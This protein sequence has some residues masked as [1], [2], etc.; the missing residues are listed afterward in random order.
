MDK[1]NAIILYLRISVEDI[2]NHEG[3]KDESNSVSNQR[4]LL[5]RYVQGQPEFTGRQIIELCDDG[6]SGTNMNRPAVTRLLEMVKKGQASC[7]IVKDFSRFGRDYLTVSD[8][9]DQIFPFMG[10]R[11]ISVNDHYDSAKCNGATSGVDMAFRNVIYGYYSQDLSIKVKSGRRTKAENGAFLSPF[12]PIGYQKAPD[13]KNQLIVETEGAEIVRQIF[14]MA[15]NGMTVIQIVRLLN[16]KQVSTPSGLKN[17]AG[18]SHKWWEG[19]GNMK[20]WDGTT[21][22]NILRDER[23]LGKNVFGK[24]E[25]IAIGSYQ[26][27]KTEKDNWIVVD[28]CHEPIITQ[29][30]FD[31]AH[32]NLKEFTGTK[33]ESSTPYL[34]SGKLRCGHCG[35]ALSRIKKPTP[36]FYCT[37]R[38]RVADCE[39]MVGHIKESEISETVLAAVRVYAKTLLDKTELLRKTETSGKIPLLQK[40]LAIL[41]TNIAGMKEQKAQLYDLLAEQSISREIFQKRQTALSR[42]EREAEQQHEASQN[43]LTRLERIV[44]NNQVQEKELRNY[45]NIDTLTREIVEALVDGIYVYN[46]KSIHIQWT[47]ENK[48]N[49]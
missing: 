1:S 30:E 29:E 2:D 4:E 42:R 39:C 34:F 18:L 25:R 11:F 23:Y 21:V 22:M 47:F 16:V 33:I 17:K 35:Y 27:R 46:D 45:I 19:A 49:H 20:L 28:N 38:R 12:A 24:R 48:I 8:Y 41:K 32:K 36:R 10:I 13:N 9:V 6:Y 37:T 15:G 44:Y 40:Q 14:Q 3:G 31:A 5:K 26:S 43:E 7:I